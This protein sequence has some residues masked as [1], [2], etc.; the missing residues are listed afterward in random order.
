MTPN[1]LKNNLLNPG[2]KF[3]VDDGVKDTTLPPGSLGFFSFF[4]KPD[5]DYQNVV[6]GTMVIIRRGKGG[7]DRLETKDIS[8][9]IFTDKRMLE[10]E[11]YLPI[12]RKLYVHIKEEPFTSKNLM[13]LKPLEFLGW[14]CS[15]NKY[16]QYVVGNFACAAKP[17]W[18]EHSVGRPIMDSCRIQ[19]HYGEGQANTLRVFGGADFRSSFIVAARKLESKLSK[20]ICNYKKAAVA[21]ILNSSHFVEHTNKNHYIVVDKRRVKDTVSFYTKKYEKISD[22]VE[23]NR[24]TNKKKGA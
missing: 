4:K 15:Y 6:H 19:E 16:L 23:K 5:R 22:L 10:H 2:I 7:Q 11:E 24:V 18:K 1:I 8:F 13:E 20:C 17:F 14:C 9:P 21:S 3:T 12:G